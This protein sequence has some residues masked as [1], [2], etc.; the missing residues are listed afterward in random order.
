[1]I[2]VLAGDLQC[3]EADFGKKLGIILI[4]EKDYQMAAST[5]VE[6]LKDYSE[7]EK[8]YFPFVGT[9]L[10]IKTA[11]TLEEKLIIVFSESPWAKMDFLTK[12]KET[13]KENLYY[14]VLEFTN[15][16]K[17]WVAEAAARRK[18]TSDE[19]IF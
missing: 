16:V 5:V 14:S 12:D 7:E 3:M 9:A 19:K 13:L 11:R 6:K 10:E 1:M 8:V 15:C 18:T 17:L 2:A 4:D